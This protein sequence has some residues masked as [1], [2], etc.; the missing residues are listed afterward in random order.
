MP[1]SCD[2]V[3]AADIL[4]I[5]AVFPGSGGGEAAQDVHQGALAGTG[6]PHDGDQFPFLDLQADMV[7]RHHAGIPHAIGL[8][9]FG[10]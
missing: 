3:Q 10:G 5:Q 9:Q 8:G 4:P 1:A 6:R 2:L 7:Q